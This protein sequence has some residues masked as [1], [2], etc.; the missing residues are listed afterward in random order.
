MCSNRSLSLSGSL[1]YQNF[2]VFNTFFGKIFQCAFY[3]KIHTSVKKFFQV[4]PH[5]EKLKSDRLCVVKNY[6]NIYIAC[7]RFLST[8]KRSKKPSLQNW[9][10]FKVFG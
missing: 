2:V 10:I 4:I 3:H 8:C 9:L 6:K 5:S 1:I 7:F